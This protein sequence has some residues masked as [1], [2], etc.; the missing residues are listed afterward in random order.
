MGECVDSVGLV[1]LRNLTNLNKHQQ[2]IG[3]PEQL[4]APDAVKG[5]SKGAR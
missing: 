5:V 3:T 4:F 2:I 1:Y